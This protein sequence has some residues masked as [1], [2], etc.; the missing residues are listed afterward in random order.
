MSTYKVAGRGE[1]NKFFDEAAYNSAVN[2]VL[3]PKKAVY[4][5]G[6]NIS[7]VQLAAQEMEETAMEFGK[8]DG[9]KVRHSVLSFSEDEHI[10]PEQANR[11]ANEI[12]KYYAQEHQV[13]YAVHANTDDVHIHFVMNHISCADGH[14]YQGKKSDYYGFMN[15]VKK[16]THLP[17]IPVK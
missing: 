13:V 7:S 8:E 15:H 5:G 4:T 3:E 10:T 6:C 9:K 16:V 12:V 2:Y 1:K 11:F 17:V 14:R